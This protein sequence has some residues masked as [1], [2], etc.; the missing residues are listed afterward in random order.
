MLTIYLSVKKSYYQIAMRMHPDRVSENEKEESSE[1]FKILTKVHDVLR[2]SHKRA[3]YDQEGVIYDDDQFERT[4]WL[5]SWEQ[6]MKNN[7][8]S[9][10][11][12]SKY[13]IG[14]PLFV[15]CLGFL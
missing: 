5:S 9:E 2:D 6:S 14:E 11:D 7:T 4:F 8:T 3:L 15:I 12:N 13:Y 10:V 1:K